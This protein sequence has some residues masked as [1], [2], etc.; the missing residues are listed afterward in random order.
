MDEQTHSAEPPPLKSLAVWVVFLFLAL[1]DLFLEFLASNL[2]LFTCH[3]LN[4]YKFY[5]SNTK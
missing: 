4:I 2:V 1:S 3:N 5:H